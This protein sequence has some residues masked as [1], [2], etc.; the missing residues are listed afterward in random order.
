MTYFDWN[1]NWINSSDVNGAP[2]TGYS[3]DGTHFNP[4]G[5]VPVGVHLAQFISTVIRG[6]A[7]V[8][9]SSQGDVYNAT[10]NPRGNLI[11]NAFCLNTTGGVGTN[12][13]GTVASNL[14]VEMATT[15]PVGTATAAASKEVRTDNRGEWQVITVTPGDAD[16][17][18]H[19]RTNTA[20]T[21]HTIPAGTWVQASME[22]SIGAFNG[23]QGV[24][25]YLKDNA[26][27]GLIAYDMEPFEVST[28]VFS[29]LPAIQMD[30]MLVTPPIQLL[31][32]SAS[33]R[34]RAEVKVAST[35]NGSSGTGVVKFG[36]F[37]L[38]VCANP[39]ELLGY[40]GG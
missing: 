10:N 13:T 4:L 22:C 18:F 3:P 21:T 14:R 32:G 28:G 16:T 40:T 20:D 30:G 2:F 6:Q 5:G 7:P 33:L 36:A 26:T 27:N 29:K 17:T 15:S 12:V 35:G 31:T 19:F 39:Q 25:L 9:V 24:S 8:R 34:V 11:T 37:E 38:R 23:W 1:R